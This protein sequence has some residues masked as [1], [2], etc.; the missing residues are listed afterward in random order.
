M[1]ELL[2]AYERDGLQYGAV[3][4]LLQAEPA[5]VEFWVDNAGYGA[6]RKVL[7]TK[8]FAVTPGVPH[9]YFF[10]GQIGSMRVDGA[11]VSFNMRIE[12]QRDA[13]TFEFSGPK[14]LVSNLVWFSGLKEHADLAHLKP[15][16]PA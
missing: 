7:Q 12:S 4:V 1:P 11:P 10:T 5:E 14:S 8:P 9:R 13:K 16:S 3:R 15:F 2:A 6:L